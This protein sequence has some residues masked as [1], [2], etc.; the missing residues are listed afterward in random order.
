M[1]VSDFIGVVLFE[2]DR[3]RE[4]ISKEIV[5]KLTE[6]YKY[7]V[8]EL[9]H[10]NIA[11]LNDSDHITAVFVVRFFTRATG[12]AGN[13]KRPVVSIYREPLSDCTVSWDY[14]MLALEDFDSLEAEIPVDVMVNHVNSNLERTQ[15]QD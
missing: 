13:I 14:D 4:K 6:T 15:K 3:A 2:E 5:L 7:R 10:G 8:K 1:K 11:I 9:L 12:L